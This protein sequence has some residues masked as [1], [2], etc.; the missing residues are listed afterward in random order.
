MALNTILKAWMRGADRVTLAPAM[1]Q[2]HVPATQTN[3]YAN[4]HI[5][6]LASNC[7]SQADN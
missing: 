4:W 5:Y 2:N 6:C 3:T 1:E 7:E